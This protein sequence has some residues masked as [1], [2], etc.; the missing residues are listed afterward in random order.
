[1]AVSGH[2]ADQLNEVFAGAGTELYFQSI[3]ICYISCSK[4][5][6]Q[7]HW[8]GS[9]HASPR[10][11][12]PRSLHCGCWLTYSNDASSENSK[13]VAELN[14][15]YFTFLITEQAIEYHIVIVLNEQNLNV[16]FASLV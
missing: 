10:G 6:E 9:P 8:P 5:Q 7:L 4:G 1:M 13:M 15:F 3:M 2:L 16:L 14:Y 11:T 12:A